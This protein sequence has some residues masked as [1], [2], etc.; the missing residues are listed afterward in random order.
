MLLLDL[1][2]TYLRYLRA[3]LLSNGL[4]GTAENAW[5]NRLVL[6]CILYQRFKFSTSHC[7]LPLSPS[8][9]E[10][11]T[12]LAG[13]APDSAQKIT[14]QNTRQFCTVFIIK[15]IR[16]YCTVYMSN[17]TVR[18]KKKASMLL[19]LYEASSSLLQIE[20]SHTGVTQYSISDP[21]I[22][23]P[24]IKYLR[25]ENKVRIVSQTILILNPGKMSSIVFVE[26]RQLSGLIIPSLTCLS[27]C[28]K[29]QNTLILDSRLTGLTL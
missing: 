17:H 7:N 1:H 16:Q 19:M 11:W 13:I 21:K 4:I 28:F 22:R 27:A 18:R 10:S 25:L 12:H 6:I 9:L 24:F 5:P 23:I 20:H 8:T 14:H 3:C 15:N 2:D 29:S 26:N